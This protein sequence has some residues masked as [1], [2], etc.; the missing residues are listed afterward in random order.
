[1]FS[2][3]REKQYVNNLKLLKETDFGKELMR[4]WRDQFVNSTALRRTELETGHALGQKELIQDIIEMSKMDEEQL[5]KVLLA[6][7]EQNARIFG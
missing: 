7:E 6:Q 1:M 3:K 5:D 4:Y 2:N